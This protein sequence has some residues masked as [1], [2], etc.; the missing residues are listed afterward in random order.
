MV[1]FDKN[2]FRSSSAW[3]KKR[4]EI[5]K[6]DHKRCKICGNKTG[7]QVHHIYS[8]DTH[9]KMKLENSNLITLCSCC[10]HKAHNQI[11]TP[12]FLLNKVL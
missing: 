6:R 12:Y 1:I 7:L 3:K 9:P 8:L 4:A 2:K 5:L 10:H 11:F